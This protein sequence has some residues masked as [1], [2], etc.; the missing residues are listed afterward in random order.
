MLPSEGGDPRSGN[1]AWSSI[2]PKHYVSREVSRIYQLGIN[3]NCLE[4]I[5][6]AYLL[7]QPFFARPIQNLKSEVIGIHGA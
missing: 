2:C 3:G 6:R 5:F 4:G 1:V 7:R